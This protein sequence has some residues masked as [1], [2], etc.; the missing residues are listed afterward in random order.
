MA[1]FLR[2]LDRAL[3]GSD[4]SGVQGTYTLL[5]TITTGPTPIPPQ[6][7]AKRPATLFS[8]P[9]GL[10]PI[11]LT[12]CDLEASI[13]HL[14]KY[15]QAH[16]R[17]HRNKVALRPL[18]DRFPAV[19]LVRDHATAGEMNEAD[20][21]DKIIPTV[22]LVWTDGAYKQIESGQRS[23]TGGIVTVD[24]GLL[25]RCTSLSHDPE[26]VSGSEEA[27]LLTLINALE[28]LLEEAQAR[29]DLGVYVEEIR[30]YL[31]PRNLLQ[32]LDK[33]CYSEKGLSENFKELFRVAKL[34]DDASIALT[35]IWCPKST[36]IPPHTKADELA[37]GHRATEL[38]AAKARLS[39][40]E[41]L[42]LQWLPGVPDR[43]SSCLAPELVSRRR[44]R[45]PSPERPLRKRGRYFD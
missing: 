7:T 1:N 11:T 12:I 33:A 27:E 22:L 44:R 39:S 10:D 6:N 21:K 43:F 25:Y 17:N 38:R 3:F 36:M 42:A 30:C 34:V 31:D 29:A 35:L 23:G 37:T 4:E 24:P 40:E 13:D 5:N 28:R 15:R 18:P 20:Y 14:P 19:V 8:I 32:Y 41:F 16:I 45:S 2:F 9:P 26:A